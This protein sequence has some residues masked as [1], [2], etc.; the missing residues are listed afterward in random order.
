LVERRNWWVY[1]IGLY[2]IDIGAVGWHRM[3]KDWSNGKGR[4]EGE[5]DI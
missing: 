2:W 1:L 4:V 5:M 3:D